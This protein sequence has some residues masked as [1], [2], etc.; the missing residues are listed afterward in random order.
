MVS[1]AKN[2]KFS[3]E[4]RFEKTTN[5]FIET[6]THSKSVMGKIWHHNCH[7]ALVKET[8]LQ[9]NNV[10]FTSGIQKRMNECS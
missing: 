7:V 4:E 5:N 6:G 9:L 10:R 2:E 1:Q 3:F 8:G